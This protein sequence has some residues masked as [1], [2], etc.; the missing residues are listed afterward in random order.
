MTG[1]LSWERLEH[2]VEPSR[3]SPRLRIDHQRHEIGFAR[4]APRRRH[5]GAVEPALRLEDAGRIDQDDLARAFDCDAAH[6]RAR[7]LRLVRDDGDLGAD[8]RIDQR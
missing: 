2:W 1:R 3:S 8:Q 5:H 7:R 6:R 4:P